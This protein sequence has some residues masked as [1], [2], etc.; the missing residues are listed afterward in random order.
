MTCRWRV[1]GL[2]GLLLGG[3]EAATF[4]LPPPGQ[5][6]VGDP[7]YDVAREEDTLVDVAARNHLGYEELILANP[8][9]DHWLPGAGTTVLLPTRYV[10]PP[11]PREGIVVNLAEFRL[12]Y[13]PKPAKKRAQRVVHVFA[14][15]A[16]RE[17]WQTPET[18]H[19][20]IVASVR[21]PSWYPPK[22]IREEHAAD[23]QPLPAVVPP[24]PD[25]PLGPLALKLGIP[26]GYFIHGSSKPFGVGM[27]V[28]HGCLRLYPDDMAA[29]FKIAP[30]GT[31]V[32]VIDQPYKTGWKNGTLYVEMHG[33]ALADRTEPTPSQTAFL[34]QALKNALAGHPHYEIDWAWVRTLTRQPKGMAVPVPPLATGVQA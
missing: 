33:P 31:P 7:G 9:V 24:G 3:A 28:T 12:Y 8:Q 23:G 15:S 6:V 34:T 4:P 16:G 14:I 5:G 18:A 19:T 30:R 17:D 1:A 26:G 22:A 13:Y 10:L 32:R 20:R 25:N 21:N 27:K 2:L 29:L 11:G